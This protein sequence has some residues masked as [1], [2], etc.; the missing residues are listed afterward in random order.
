[1]CL[2]HGSKQRLILHVVF[3]P[4]FKTFANQAEQHRPHIQILP[5]S[6]SRF[7]SCLKQDQS[8]TRRVSLGCPVLDATFG[9]GLPGHGIVDISGMAGAGKTQLML[10]LLVQQV[11]D[12]ESEWRNANYSTPFVAGRSFYLST[13]GPLPAKRLADMAAAACP[14]D[15]GFAQRVLESVIIVEAKNVEDQL[16]LLTTQLPSL[17]ADSSLGE[18]SPFVCCNQS[19]D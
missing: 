3:T 2:D 9:G 10:Q 12:A 17:L 7:T 15:S 1:M 14:G 19:L 8:H 5:P 6:V 11:K 4:C 18:L 16:Y 13:E